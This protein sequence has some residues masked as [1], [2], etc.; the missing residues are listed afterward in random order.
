MGTM[1]HVTFTMSL[2]VD[3]SRIKLKEPA[4]LLL[5]KIVARLWYSIKVKRSY[6]L[7]QFS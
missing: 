2:P 3:V 1:I 5:D 6:D 4:H 7:I